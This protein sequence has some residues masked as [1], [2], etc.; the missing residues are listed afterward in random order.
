MIPRQPGPT[1][2][3]S[4]VRFAATGP[5]DAM[6]AVRGIVDDAL[7]QRCTE[8]L[9]VARRTGARYLLVDVSEA[10]GD[11]PASLLR[12]LLALRA[13]LEAVG[14]WLVV[15]GLP[16]EVGIGEADLATVFDAYRHARPAMAVTPL[17][18]VVAAARPVPTA[19]P[20]ALRRA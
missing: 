10:A 14:G 9:A 7:A 4:S 20:A 2:C 15:D 8:L 6:L 1:S 12:A 18:T 5:R 11:L 13:D 19:G 16:D 3:P 17:G